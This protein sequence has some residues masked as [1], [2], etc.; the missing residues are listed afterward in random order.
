MVPLVTSVSASSWPWGEPVRGAGAA[1][2]HQHVELPHGQFVAGEG[3]VARA[4]QPAREPADPREHRQWSEVQVGA[5]TVPGR[6]HLVDVVA[7]RSLGR[8]HGGT[9]RPH[10][11]PGAGH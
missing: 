4:V 1:Q 6:D 8:R 11:A 9:H 3:H 10:L 7:C 2:R 5:L